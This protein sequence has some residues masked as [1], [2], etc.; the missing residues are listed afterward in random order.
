[1]VQIIDLHQKMSSHS[2]PQFTN[3]GYQE[4]PDVM[5]RA[6][7]NIFVTARNRKVN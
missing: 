3:D 1:L 7:K 4:F 5:A 6:A 2:G